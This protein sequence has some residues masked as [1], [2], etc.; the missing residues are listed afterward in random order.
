MIDV[1]ITHHNIDRMARNLEAFMEEFPG[2]VVK[3]R[4]TISINVEKGMWKA[5][6]LLKKRDVT[7]EDKYID[8]TPYFL[9]SESALLGALVPSSIPDVTRRHRMTDALVENLKDAMQELE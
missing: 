4:V 1:P 7:Q 9:G 3:R 8:A 2:E 6:I 5:K